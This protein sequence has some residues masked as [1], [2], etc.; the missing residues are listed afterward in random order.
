MHHLLRQRRDARFAGVFALLV[1]MVSLGGCATTPSLSAEA[2]RSLPDRVFVEDV[3]FHGQREYQC[4]PASLAMALAASGVD[5]AVDD[6]IPQVF[7]PGRQGSVQPEMLATVRRHGRIP[8]RL[9]GG[10]AGLLAELDAGRPVVVMQNLS[11]PWWPEW[12][13]ALAIGY[14]RPAEQIILH[15]GMT[16][17]RRTGFARFEATWARSQRW[18]FSALTPG[19]MPQHVDP[20]AALRAISNFSEVQGPVAALPAWQAL[21]ERHPEQAMAHFALGNARYANGHVEAAIDAF[22]EA[23]DR[24]PGMGEAWLNLGLLLQAQGRD[25]AAQKALEKAADTSGPWQQ[26]ARQELKQRQKQRST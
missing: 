9:E 12:H 25:A 20:D 4:G 21:V 18:G 11:L 2:A 16:P 14:D 24:N 22:R 23:T 17:Q 1:L 26:R 19:K 8:F 5:V 15:S 3:P 10:F 6:L 7:L 13:Y